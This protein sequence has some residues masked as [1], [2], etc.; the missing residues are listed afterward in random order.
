[1]HKIT[2]QIWIGGSDSAGDANRLRENGIRYIL[3]CAEDLPE[4]L[5]WRDGFTHF[6]C[7]MRDSTNHA[8]LYHAALRILDAIL[9]DKE[10]KV[11]VHCHE[12][13]SRSVYVVACFLFECG[14]FDSV[15]AAIEHI[16]QCGR[17]V[18]VKAGH[19]DSYTPW[20]PTA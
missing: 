17:D 14:K 19:F 16:R 4:Q 2:D 1:M 12:G 3:N 20:R 9:C 13:R 15:D 8:G 5:S 6:H 18:S 11:V 7:G 10:N